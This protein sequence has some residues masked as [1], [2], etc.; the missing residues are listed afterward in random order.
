MST[1]DEAGALRQAVNSWQEDL[2]SNPATQTL[3]AHAH[4]AVSVARTFSM[5]HKR[6][7][8]FATVRRT[9]N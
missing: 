8:C 2:L 1:N 5:R 3:L 9:I 7:G 4:E 6:H